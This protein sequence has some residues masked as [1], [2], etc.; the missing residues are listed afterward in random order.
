[1]VEITDPDLNKVV[2][3]FEE[4]IAA[5]ERYRETLV[6]RRDSHAAEKRDPATYARVYALN[7]R[8]V[9][10]LY[11]EADGELYDL[12]KTLLDGTGTLASA[13]E[14]RWI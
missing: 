4:M 8:R 11:E 3:H 9:E 14:G 13:D 5:I 6:A 2:E 7:L 12:L 10:R 1:M